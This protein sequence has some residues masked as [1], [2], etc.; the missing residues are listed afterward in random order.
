[1]EV[2]EAPRQTHRDLVSDPEALASVVL[3]AGALLWRALSA[4]AN[5]DFL[6]SIREE[7]FAIMFA[8][9]KLTAWWIVGIGS[10][11]WL[12][13]RFF[14]KRSLVEREY[15]GWPLLISSCIVE[16]LFGA[17]LAVKSTG[18]VPKV[19]MRWTVGDVNRCSSTV[20]TNRLMTFATNYKLAVVCLA[21]NQTVDILE[22]DDITVSNLYTIIQGGIDVVPQTDPRLKVALSKN[23]N[24]IDYFAVIVPSGITKEKITKLQDVISLGG[25]ILTEPLYK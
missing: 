1:M 15:P 23:G 3:G 20:D 24:T 5:V 19:L 6:L 14:K 9:F 25:K 13:S 11:I 8:F 22:N 10:L 4:W 21:P 7:K 12:I 2:T 17:L 18:S 16:F